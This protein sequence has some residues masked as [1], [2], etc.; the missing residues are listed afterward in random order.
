[1]PSKDTSVSKTRKVNDEIK[2]PAKNR[3]TA[4]KKHSLFSASTRHNREQEKKI[5]K[6]MKNLGIENMTIENYMSSTVDRPE[7]VKVK[8]VNLLQAFDGH[9]L[10][11][12]TDIPAGTQLGM[13]TGEHYPTTTSFKHYLKET[14]GADWSY[15]MT[16]G[17]RVVDAQVKG[18]FTRYINF[19][20]SQ[21]NVEFREAVIDGQKCVV[22]VTTKDIA[23]GQ[24]FL[25]DY[26]CYDAHASKDYFFLS[27]A[28]NWRSADEVLQE[29][30]RSYRAYVMNQDLALL[31]LQQGEQVYVSRVGAAILENELLAQKRITQDEIN[32]PLLKT[33][34]EHQ[35]LDF[36]QADS[37]TALMLATYLGQLDNV[38][39]LVANQANIDQQQNNSGNCPL[40]FALEGYAAAPKRQKRLYLEIL[41]FLIS[42]QSNVLVHDREDRTFLHK[43]IN[44]LSKDDFKKLMS[45]VSSQK[46]FNA[47][48]AF[49]YIDSNNLD[50]ILYSLTHKEFDKAAV[51]LNLYPEYFTKNYLNARNKYQESVNR[52]PLIELIEHYDEDDKATLFELLSNVRF[53]LPEEFVEELGLTAISNEYF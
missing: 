21:E 24:Q 12:H 17:Y 53:E 44:V 10:Y 20:D 22:V 39:W 8:P 4:M 16:L 34:S 49:G 37:F 27:P 38:K 5:Q 42:S 45:F 11:A 19:S 26:N 25:V 52:K 31:Q 23:K 51:L 9:G 35:V 1:M 14:H 30:F 2:H 3:S 46:Q 47:E 13:Y 43:V 32:L 7:L 29:N 41:C 36:N 15:A 40:F 28:D 48:E 18:N 33:D 50:V 6:I